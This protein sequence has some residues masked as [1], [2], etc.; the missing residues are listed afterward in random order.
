MDNMPFRQ[1]GN[2]FITGE[3]RPGDGVMALTW[4]GLIREA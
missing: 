1:A 4:P 2:G 3:T